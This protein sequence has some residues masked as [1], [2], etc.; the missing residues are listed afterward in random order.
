MPEPV[1]LVSCPSYDEAHVTQA[2]A[3]AL[4]LL[5][6]WE[7][8]F[9]PEGP[10]YLKPNL[11]GPF[12]PERGV[13]THPAVVKAVARLLQSAGREVIVGD[14][15]AGPARPGYL[16]FLYRRTGME[17]VARELDLQLDRALEPV[18]VKIPNPR[19][20]RV[21]T[22]NRSFAEA[23]PLF[24]LP[25]FK[26][27]LFARLTGAVKNLYGAVSGM[28]KVAYHTRLKNSEDF[29]GLLLDLADYLQPRLSVV[30]AVVGMEG[31]GPTWGR[32]R[33]V[34]Y[35]LA[36]ANPLAVDWV[37]SQMMGFPEGAV[38]LFQM[39]P[40]PPVEVRGLSLEQVRLPDFLLPSPNTLEDGLE[41]LSWLP[42]RLKE[43]LGKELLP[44]P[45]INQRLCAGC[46]LCEESCPQ[47]AI[48]LE[49]HKAVVDLKLCIRCWCCNEV[50]PQGAVELSRSR[51]GRLL[52]SV[53]LN[54]M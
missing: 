19:S 50:C 21:L 35:L 40:P 9:P 54:K 46:S 53:P 2:L 30:D 13:T 36:G 34:G 51:L 17:E 38:P 14:S 1:A 7:S 27:H 24:N 26:T 39:A 12:P 22:L 41:G 28:M 48:H 25:K 33:P 16:N 11:A 20:L 47:E 52:A 4:N 37:M 32:V 43:Y 49:D 3:A 10:I 5:G 18:E 6:G 44:H 23:P 42:R 45:A 29:M 8:L 31:D 15:P